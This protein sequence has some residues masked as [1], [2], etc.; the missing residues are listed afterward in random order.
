MVYG[1]V[2]TLLYFWSVLSYAIFSQLYKQR[3]SYCTVLYCLIFMLWLVP[4]PCTKSHLWNVNKLYSVLLKL[5][6]EEW[7]RLLRLSSL[8]VFHICPHLSNALF[9]LSPPLQ[10][11]ILGRSDALIWNRTNSVIS[12]AIE[13]RRNIHKCTPIGLGP[14]YISP[15]YDRS[16]VLH[17]VSIQY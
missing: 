8:S 9:G 7:W 6:M 1:N 15:T 17:R 12:E 14:R 16:N 13:A 4:Y 3:V 10:H 11:N 5:L 2:N